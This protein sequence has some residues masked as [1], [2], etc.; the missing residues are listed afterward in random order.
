MS[1]DEEEE[2]GDTSRISM[3]DLI[4]LYQRE[5]DK[6]KEDVLQQVT[7]AKSNLNDVVILD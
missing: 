3:F 7:T 2:D 4:T 5:I 1:E 6:N